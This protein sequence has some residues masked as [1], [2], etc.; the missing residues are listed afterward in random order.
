MIIV[1][2]PF[3]VSLIGGGTDFPEYYNKFGGCVIGLKMKHKIIRKGKEKR[4]KLRKEYR[5]M[6]K[7]G[8][9]KSI[10]YVRFK[11]LIIIFLGVLSTDFLMCEAKPPIQ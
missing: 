2:V 7:Q 5:K 11:I 1:R 10:G 9:R 6:R 3:R 8:R 4:R